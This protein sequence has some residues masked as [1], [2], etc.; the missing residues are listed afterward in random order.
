MAKGGGAKEML[1]L[2]VTPD[3]KNAKKHTWAVYGIMGRPCLEALAAARSRSDCK[4]A[5]RPVS[6]R[7]PRGSRARL[8]HGRYL[9][10]MA[11]HSSPAPTAIAHPPSTDVRTQ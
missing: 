9:R 10:E 8:E 3:T 7:R 4:R 5:G 11:Q 2:M 1:T 6:L